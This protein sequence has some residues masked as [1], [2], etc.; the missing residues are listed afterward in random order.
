MIGSRQWREQAE[1]QWHSLHS[2]VLHPFDPVKAFRRDTLRE[3]DAQRPRRWSGCLPWRL[4]DRD[5]PDALDRRF[6]A[7]LDVQLGLHDWAER[8]RY[9]KHQ[10]LNFWADRLADLDNADN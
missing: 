10:D 5:Q 6:V 2:S 1:R 4:H 7:Y 8:L 3:I 9:L